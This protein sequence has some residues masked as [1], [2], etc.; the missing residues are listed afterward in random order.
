MGGAARRIVVRFQYEWRDASGVWL[1][2]HANFRGPPERVPLG[3]LACANSAYKPSLS[4]WT[5]LLP[6]LE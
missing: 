1:R 3:I 5:A 4:T 6:T 2:A